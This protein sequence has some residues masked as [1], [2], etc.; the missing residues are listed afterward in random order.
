MLARHA[1]PLGRRHALSSHN[2]RVSFGNTGFATRFSSDRDGLRPQSPIHANLPIRKALS[3]LTLSKPPSCSLR[4]RRFYSIV[5]ISYQ[6]R[7]SLQGGKTWTRAWL[8][9][10][11]P[12]CP[13]CLL[14]AVSGL[15]VLYGLHS[16]WRDEYNGER[17]H[18]SLGYRTPNEFAAVLKSSVMTG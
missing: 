8:S 16:A 11:C 6:I 2:P 17:P 13:E 14:E 10:G 15:T 9:M 12:Q 1:P 7:Y 3:V 5:G 18:S 4:R